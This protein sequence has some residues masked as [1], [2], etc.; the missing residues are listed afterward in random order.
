MGAYG[1]G[2]PERVDGCARCVESVTYLL[3][4]ELLS[5]NLALVAL[6]TWDIRTPPETPLDFACDP[7]VT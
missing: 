3:D 2:S 5:L 4:L 6:G 7:G 1:E